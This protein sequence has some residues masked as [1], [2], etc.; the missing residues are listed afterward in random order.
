[1]TGSLYC[2]IN[3]RSL[4]RNLECFQTHLL[5]ELDFRFSLIALTET[6]ITDAKEIDLNPNICGYVFEYVP[7]PLSAGGVG[8]YIS[9]NLDYTIIERTYNPA[10]QAL[11]I[12]IFVPNKKNIICGVLYRQ[13]NSP[14]RF[15]SYFDDTVERLNSSGKL[16][17]IVGDFNIDLLK[18]GRCNMR[19]TF[20][21]RY[22]VI[23]LSLNR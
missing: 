22:R 9:E 7:T 18:S 19:I 2:T 16:I 21:S 5:G 23:L 1:M 4:K 3:I 20:Y 8:M 10:F 13:H 17:Y 6:R 12:E 11:W 14:E 15:L